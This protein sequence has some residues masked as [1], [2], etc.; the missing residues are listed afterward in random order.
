MI[1]RS[2][3]SLHYHASGCY[4][5]LEFSGR[6]ARWGIRTDDP[7]SYGLRQHRDHLLH[8]MLRALRRYLGPKWSPI[9][10][11]VEYDRP[12]NWRM[13]EQEIGAPVVFGSNANAILFEARLLGRHALQQMPV[14]EIFTWRDLRQIVMHRPPRTKVEAAREIVRLRLFDSNVDIDG[15][16]KLLG[17]AART[18]QRQLAEENLSYRD[19]VQELRMQRALDLLRESCEPITSIAISQGYSDVASI[20][21]A[22]RQWAGT[23]PSHH[24]RT[25]SPRP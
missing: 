6:L 10:I 2:V 14:K 24:R 19:L 17:I 25:L 4:F 12:P 9:Q 13:V 21:R 15:A 11:E 20:S 7:S 1:Q 23:P 22:F 18:L 8:P 5:S 16:A 3:R